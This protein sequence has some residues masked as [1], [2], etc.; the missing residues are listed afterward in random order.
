MPGLVKIGMTDRNDVQRRMTELFT[1]GVP[2]PFECVIA[3]EIEDR[4]AATVESALHR[5][6][7]PYRA[8]ESRE[9]FQIES[10]Q[11][12]VLLQILPGRDVTPAIDKQLAGSS[13]E[14]TAAAEEF[15]KRRAKTNE[16][17]F[18][19]SFTGHGRDVYER[20]LALGRQ[21]GMAIKWGV[22]GFSLN[23]LHEGARIVVCYGYPPAS[24]YRGRIHTDF[25]MATTKANVPP[26][27]I[28]AHRKIA[29]D[30]RLF[31]HVGRFNELACDTDRALD[32][33]QITEITQ[34][35]WGFVELIR[36]HATSTQDQR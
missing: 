28:E 9:F 27:K 18:L 15:K 3:K 22:S 26:E 21:Q 36:T 23:V 31:V 1:T 25:S 11:A 14:D 33:P 16:E 12:E 8:N 17:E 2:F 32:E 4:E 29:L 35:L 19:A 10:E 6:F 20:V 34:W 24:P 5:A 30:G 13:P 7:S